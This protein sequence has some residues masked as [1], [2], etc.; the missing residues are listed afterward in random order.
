M[1]SFFTKKLSDV[2]KGLLKLCLTHKDIIL[3]E[4]LV[5]K[6]TD[7]PDLF[8]NLIDVELVTVTKKELLS[9]LLFHQYDYTTRKYLRHSFVKLITEYNYKPQSLLRY[10]DNL[11]TY[12]ALVRFS[13]TC[14]ELYDY[15]TMM[16]KISPKFEKYPKNFLTTHRIAAR[17]YNRLKETF[18]EID[19]EK[20]IDKSL[21]YGFGEYVVIYPKCTQDIKDEAVQLNH[22][23]ASYISRVIK[24]ECHILFLRRKEDKEKS[25]ITLE[26][27]NGKVVQARGKF[28]R[29]VS[30]EEQGIVDRYN[31]VL[32][33]REERGV[34]AAC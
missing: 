3:T 24:G 23:V 31:K 18:V 15:V 2:P 33:L 1:D 26:V 4:N 25:L 19:F 9:V 8:N 29:D 10:I 28:N 16:A 7:T 14:N 12:E 6:Y 30:A 27:R 13:E 20:Q 34:L 5:D 22:C 11:M 32:Q 21:E 17:N